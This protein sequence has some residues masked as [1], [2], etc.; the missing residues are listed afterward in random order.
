M[1]LASHI[2]VKFY[3]RFPHPLPPA[4]VYNLMRSRGVEPTVATFGTLISIASDASDSPR[5]KEAWGWLRSSGLEV[6][7]TCANSFLQA[8]IKEVRL[9]GGVGA[10]I[11]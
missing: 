3:A 4:Q 7:I 2:H 5:V 1:D 10:P 9:P 11:S 6:H 8:L